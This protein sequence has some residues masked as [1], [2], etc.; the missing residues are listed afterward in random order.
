MKLIKTFIGKIIKRKLESDIV[1]LLL[2]LLAKWCYD[3]LDYYTFVE[4]TV[5]EYS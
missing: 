5:Y 1:F 3:Q 2:R 4:K